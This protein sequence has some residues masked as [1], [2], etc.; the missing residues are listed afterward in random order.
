MFKAI[1]ID[2]EKHCR[3][4]LRATL[5][6]VSDD[7]L[8]VKECTS[9]KEGLEAVHE[10][11]PDLVFLDVE[12]GKET[13]FDFLK[14][15]GDIPFEVIFTTAHE[16]YALRAIK[17]CALDFLLKPIGAEDLKQALHKFGQRV[18]KANSG[19]QIQ[20][21]MHNL[22]SLQ[23]ESKKVALPTLT[24]LQFVSVH[25]IVRCESDINYTIFYLV[26]KSKIVVSKTLKEFEG[27]LEECNFFR[28][29][30]SHLIN[31]SHIKNYTKGEGGTVTMDDGS[32]V[33]VS[34]RRK[35]EFLHKISMQ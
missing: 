25:D 24:G 4:S 17:F 11:V 8:V 5:G 32:T 21:L 22:K 23:N 6:K 15:L 30:N 33:D 29:H 13:G 19:K 27:L 16:N 14:Q 31:L 12:M 3:D 28:V 10:L 1:I 34:R 35:E 9:P 26:D 2:D 20:E 18:G 7:V